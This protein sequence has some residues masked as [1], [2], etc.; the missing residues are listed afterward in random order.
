MSTPG[1]RRWH[2]GSGTRVLAVHGLVL[3]LVLGA[4]TF[5]VVHGFSVHYTHTIVADLSEEG[6]EYAHAAAHRPAGQGMEAFSRSYL[7]AHVLGRGHLVVVGLS[8]QAS[9]AS[10]G[11]RV[12]A[13]S[14][15]VAAWLSRPPARSQLENVQ[16]GTTTYLV[17]ASPIRTPNGTTIGV[18]VAAADL[19]HLR[20]ERNQVLILAGVEAGIALAVAL[21]SSFLVLRRVLRTVGAVT[22]AA[23]EAN[24]ANLSARFIAEGAD[25]EVGRLTAAFDGMLER[26]AAGLDAQRQLLSDVSHQLRTPLTVARG[27]LEV[28]ERNPAPEHSEVAETTA[29]VISELTRMATLIDRLLLLGRSFSPDFIEEGPVDLRMFMGELVDTARVLAERQWTLGEVPDV[30]IEVDGPKLRGALLNLVDNS[31]KATNP[32]DVISLAARYNGEVVINVSD[33]G[34]GIALEAQQE[35]FERFRR[36][37]GRQGSG[38]GLAIVKAVAEAHGGRVDLHSAEGVGTSIDIVIPAGR[39]HHSITDT[40][41]EKL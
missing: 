30:V 5:E 22:Q 17:L 33:T 24:V 2:L 34:L 21:L 16:V 23:V 36:A 25:D 15:L 28:L 1:V 20:N 26:I 32:G 13:S 39:V 40:Q 19:E 18:L 9:L 3:G 31:V 41:E 8:G 6:F 38:L 4:V 11:G 35:V 37:G 14:P 29:T 12:L 27:H 7:Q 10:S